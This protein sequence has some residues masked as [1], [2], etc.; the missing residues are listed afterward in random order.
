MIS[1]L[2]FH[3]VLSVLSSLTVFTAMFNSQVV[4]L[5]QNTNLLT[6]FNRKFCLILIMFAKMFNKI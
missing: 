6:V 5:A 3:S 4:E 1:H 2:C